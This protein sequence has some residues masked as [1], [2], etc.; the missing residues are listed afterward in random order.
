MLRG[1]ATL[2][3]KWHDVGVNA[4]RISVLSKF[5]WAIPMLEFNILMPPKFVEGCDSSV[6]SII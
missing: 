3:G 2:V 4:T 1:L 5:N 6:Y